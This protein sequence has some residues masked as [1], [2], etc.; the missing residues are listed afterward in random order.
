MRSW[1]ATY[2]L[3]VEVLQFFNG[4]SIM[5]PRVFRLLLL[6]QMIMLWWRRW[7]RR[8]RLQNALERRILAHEVHGRDSPVYST[9]RSYDA[10]WSLSSEIG[11][12]RGGLPL[13]RDRHRS[14]EGVGRERDRAPRAATVADTQKSLLGQPPITRGGVDVGDQRTRGALHALPRRARRTSD[15]RLS[16]WCT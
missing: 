5:F 8:L 2:D 13:C 6:L 4:G 14:L 3:V 7:W 10:V 9:L 16:A 1:E 12:S 15:A 11:E